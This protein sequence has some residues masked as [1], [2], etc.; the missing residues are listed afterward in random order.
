MPSSPRTALVYYWCTG[1]QD[2]DSASGTPRRFT[3]KSAKKES[4][5]D[6][7]RTRDLRHAKA[8]LSQLSYGPLLAVGNQPSPISTTLADCRPLK[9]GDAGFI[10]PATPAVR[11]IFIIVH[12]AARTNLVGAYLF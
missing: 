12:R 2:G 6:E 7:T 8:A 3:C 4:G 5:P 10:Q 11:Q 9:S 1:A